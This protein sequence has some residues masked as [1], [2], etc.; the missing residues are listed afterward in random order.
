MNMDTARLLAPARFLAAALSVAAFAASPSIVDG[1]TAFGLLAGGLL[2]STIVMGS[3]VLEIRLRAWKHYMLTVMAGAAA[4]S[5]VIFVTSGKMWSWAAFGMFVLLC[6]AGVTA[7]TESGADPV[8]AFG[9]SKVHPNSRKFL[10]F[11]GGCGGAALG[12]AGLGPAPNLLGATALAAFAF[13]A[14]STVSSEGSW[15]ILKYIIMTGIVVLFVWRYYPSP[16]PV[17]P[18]SIMYWLGSEGWFRVMDAD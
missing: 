15:R 5:A 3:T 9:L 12:M 4:S 16:L 17:V 10:G 2:A 18:A 14:V 1:F 13:V 11:L 6:F 8:I 7:P